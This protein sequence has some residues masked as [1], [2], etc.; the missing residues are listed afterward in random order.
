MDTTSIVKVLLSEDNR[1]RELGEISRDVQNYFLC[2]VLF[3]HCLYKYSS[4]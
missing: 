1:D 2:H 3:V 4:N